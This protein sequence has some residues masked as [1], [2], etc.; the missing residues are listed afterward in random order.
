MQDDGFQLSG[1]FAADSMCIGMF[2][3]KKQYT[4]PE[5]TVC[6]SSQTFF[7]ANSESDWNWSGRA[8]DTKHIEAICGLGKE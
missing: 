5:T 1:F 4:N 7:L 2:G 6:L 8:T 3:N